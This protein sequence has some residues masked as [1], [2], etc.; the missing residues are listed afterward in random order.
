MDILPI[1]CVAC[2]ASQ[3]HMDQVIV[4]MLSKSVAASHL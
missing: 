1:F 4:L 2:E 3:T